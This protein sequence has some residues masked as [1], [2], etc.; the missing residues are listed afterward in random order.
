MQ[1]EVEIRIT[2]KDE[3]NL[4]PNYA[5]NPKNSYPQFCLAE[6]QGEGKSA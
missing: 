4:R 3:Q 2:M 1:N 6:L 5:D